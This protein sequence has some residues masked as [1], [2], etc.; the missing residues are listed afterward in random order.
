MKKLMKA[1]IT[2]I[3]II[4][5]IMTGLFCVIR[6]F[7]PA[8]VI[9][10]TEEEEAAQKKAS[11]EQFKEVNLKG[12]K[13]KT[14]TGEEVT[15]EIFSDYKVTMINIWST[16]CG[17]CIE[18]MPEI[19]KLYK[20]LPEGSNIISICTDA[21]DGEEYLELANEIMTKSN[22]D[23]MTLIPDEFLKTNLTNDI[24]TLPTT[25]FVDSEGK[26]VGEPHFSGQTAED[27]RN[28]INERL[29]LVEK[30]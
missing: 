15:S 17:P 21:G 9:V 28:S 7:G 12:F 27:Y 24:Q 6:F 10:L 26:V 13:A 23:F 2:I 19:G 3:V 18:E 1:F 16:W 4:A 25:I 11:I 20:D 30:Q 8:D 5:V 22:A 29:K 14:I